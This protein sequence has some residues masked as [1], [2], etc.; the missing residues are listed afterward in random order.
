[1]GIKKSSNALIYNL[2]I[3]DQSNPVFEFIQ[4]N[5]DDVWV[6]ADTGR[7]YEGILQGA[8]IGDYEYKDEPKHNLNLYFKDEDG[9]D[10]KVS[11]NFNSLALGLM[12]TLANEDTLV[13]R[14]IEISVWEKNEMPKMFIKIDGEDGSWKYGGDVVKTL[15]KAGD[16]KWIDL[17]NADI[18]PKLAIA[19]QVTEAEV[20]TAAPMDT[21]DVAG[22]EVVTTAEV[23]VIA[24]GS[25]DFDFDDL[26]F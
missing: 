26:P 11:V 21:I 10:E 25:D 2:R 22:Q 4:K 16:A 15:F 13:G 8:D 5:S 20:A 14:K 6:V 24:G 1:M 19:A 17:F 7:N 9:Q 3:K 12:N 23:P 18:K